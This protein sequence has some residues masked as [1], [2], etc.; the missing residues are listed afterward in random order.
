MRWRSGS[1]GYSFKR[2]SR[3]ALAAFAFPSARSF[4]P[5]LQRTSSSKRLAPCARETP[6]NRITMGKDRNLKHYS[7]ILLIISSF[8]PSSLSLSFFNPCLRPTHVKKRTSSNMPTM[9]MLSGL[10][11]I[12][13]K[14]CHPV[15]SSIKSHH[16]ARKIHEELIRKS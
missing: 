16:L 5:C 10:V 7:H 11:T 13:K 14:F 2:P 15:S 6:I 9:G 4:F 8:F 3:A 12:S 1:L